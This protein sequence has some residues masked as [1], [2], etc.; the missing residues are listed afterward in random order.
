MKD[1]GFESQTVGG[2]PVRGEC[3]D[4]VGISYR[5]RGFAPGGPTRD[6]RQVCNTRS[7]ADRTFQIH[8]V[9]IGGGS[10]TIS[11]VGMGECRLDHSRSVIVVYTFGTKIVELLAN[12]YE[13]IFL[14]RTIAG[15]LWVEMAG[16][17][18]GGRAGVD[19][20]RG[21]VGPGGD[22]T[23]I[24]NAGG[25]SSRGG[26]LMRMY[27]VRRRDGSGGLVG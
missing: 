3:N 6:P 17:L 22:S 23:I 8:R 12:G 2:V 1:L 27:L 26:L 5:Y 10:P 15:I 4:E 16:V 19:L 21:L 14:E 20:A 9:P 7:T 11:K 25:R 18:V 13:S 24:P